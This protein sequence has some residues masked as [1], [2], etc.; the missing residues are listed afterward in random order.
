MPAKSASVE[1]DGRFHD[2]P[3]AMQVD[4]DALTLVFCDHDKL[5]RK[6]RAFDVKL[7]P[8][9]ARITD[10]RAAHAARALRPAAG[11]LVLAV[12]GEL[13]AEVEIV[14]VAGAAQLQI[15]PDGA[16]AWRWSQC[17]GSMA[18]P[19]S[20]FSVPAPLQLPGNSAKGPSA[21][22]AGRGGMAIAA[23]R[24]HAGMA[25][26]ASAWKIRVRKGRFPFKVRVELPKWGHRPVNM[27]WFRF[28]SRMPVGRLQSLAAILRPV[29]S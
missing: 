13:T 23:S 10:G 6:A 25:I 22:E 27:G 12:D 1:A 21:A 3:G 15:V 19:F 9:A 29:V 24:A 4:G 17:S 8:V 5:G 16:L 20:G 28:Q 18:A 7:Q 14:A 2:L 11:D 26:R